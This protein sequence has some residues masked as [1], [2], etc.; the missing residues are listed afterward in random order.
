MGKNSHVQYRDNDSGRFV[1]TKK[2]ENM[3]KR[4][5]TREHV[6]NPGRGDTGRK[7]K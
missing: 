2:G 3:P 7:G 6:P 1:P 5:V 4:D